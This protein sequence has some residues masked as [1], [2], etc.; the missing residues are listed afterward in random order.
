MI[1]LDT[2]V[3][4]EL[5]HSC[6]HPDVVAW[7]DELPVDEIYLTAVTAAELRYGIARL[8][9][10]RRKTDLAERVRQTIDEDLTGRVLPFDGQASSQY[11]DFVVDRERRG[12]PISI[13]DAQIA[14][15]CRTHSVD[16]A[17]RNTKDFAETG[18]AVIDPWQTA[19]G[20]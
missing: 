6:A 20:E 19:A 7:L 3:I 10:G 15:I 13:A 12:M 18:I 17:T 8:P 4:S 14:A 5:M 2:N 9:D 1:V 16:L 11:A